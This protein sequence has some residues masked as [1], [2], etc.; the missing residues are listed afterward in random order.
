LGYLRQL[1]KSGN[2]LSALF[3]LICLFAALLTGNMTQSNSAA[4]ALESFDISPWLCAFLFACAAWL[5][6]GAKESG[7]MRLTALFITPLT[8]FYLILCALV[9]WNC[10]SLLPAVFADIFASAFGIDSIFGAIGGCAMRDAVRYGLSRGIFSNEAGM[11]TSPIAY[12][13]SNNFSSEKQGCLG[14]AEVFIDTTVC[15]TLTGLVLLLSNADPSADGA[16]FAI[17]AF[18]AAL[19]KKA[20][21]AAAL[22]IALFALASVCGWYIYGILSLKRLI[23]KSENALRLY[24]ILYALFAGAGVFLQVKTIWLVSD[25]LTG[26]MLM[27]NLC[28]VIMLFLFSK[29]SVS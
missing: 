11:G 29:T 6:T 13:L 25:I 20:G 27:I 19:G 22:M 4:Q 1:G 5:M 16:Q 14:A 28:G 18:A 7:L 2:T 26:L 12:S 21:I 8:L 17:N 23:P 9:V 15:C 24:R 3:A 10:R